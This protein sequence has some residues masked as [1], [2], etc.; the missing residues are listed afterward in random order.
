MLFFSETP[1]IYPIVLTAS[2][3]ELSGSSTW[4]VDEASTGGAPQAADDALYGL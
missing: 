3:Y 1:C 4:V 2:P